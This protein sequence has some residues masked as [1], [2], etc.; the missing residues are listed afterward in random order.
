MENESKDTESV[1]H[2]DWNLWFQQAENGD[3]DAVNSIIEASQPFIRSLG[4][5]RYF[6]KRMSLDEI[7]SNA[8]Y[9]LLKFIQKH[10]ELPNDEEVP[11]LLQSV[12]RR[13]MEDCIRHMDFQEMHEQLAKPVHAKGSMA[14]DDYLDNDCSEA[15]SDDH[16][17]EPE[18]CCL[19]SE[20][21][22]MVRDAIRQLPE[23]EKIV[24][25]GFY[26]QHKGMKEI[27]QDLQCSFQYAY[28]TR[29]KAYTH[30]HK[31]LKKTVYA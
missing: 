12:L 28:I 4:K 25:N 20:L 1:N 2:T 10:K 11:Y 9:S 24:I 15:P 21:C 17:T 13:D 30:L 8:N 18:V 16:T 14:D 6:R 26:F 7:N 29:N 3:K 19:K 23:D 31:L 22:D 27:A 5:N